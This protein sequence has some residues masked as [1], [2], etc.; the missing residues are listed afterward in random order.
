MKNHIFVKS[1]VQSMEQFGQL[2][3]S[4]KATNYSC[5]RGLPT[6]RRP[7]PYNSVSGGMDYAE[8]F[9]C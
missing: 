4:C 5:Q 7:V 6:K 8:A 9:V 1:L 3:D 2:L